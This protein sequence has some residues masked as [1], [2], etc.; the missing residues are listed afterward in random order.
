MDDDIGVKMMKDDMTH[1]MISMRKTWRQLDGFGVVSEDVDSGGAENEQ[2]KERF[3]IFS[4]EDTDAIWQG[5]G[6]DSFLCTVCS[7]P[8]AFSLCFPPF[9]PRGAPQ[10]SYTGDTVSS[11]RESGACTAGATNTFGL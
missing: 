11:N 1:L 2:R 7:L 8:F 5:H 10:C 6:Q 3:V 4:D 9:S